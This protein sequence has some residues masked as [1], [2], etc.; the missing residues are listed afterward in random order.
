MSGSHP[1]LQVH[2]VIKELRF[3]LVLSHHDGNTALTEHRNLLHHFLFK[4]SDLG[5]K[6]LRFDPNRP[7]ELE[8][9]WHAP[10]ASA[11]S[12]SYDWGPAACR[13]WNEDVFSPF[14]TQAA[15]VGNLL[16]AAPIAH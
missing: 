6:P 12:I 8:I 15:F 14:E 5:N 2:R 10:I 1:L 13:R 4:T 7:I 3:A 9:S 11:P 16:I